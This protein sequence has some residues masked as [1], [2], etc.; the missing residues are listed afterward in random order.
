MP[1]TP[2]FRESS[3]TPRSLLPRL[4]LA[5]AMLEVTEVEEAQRQYLAQVQADADEKKK[6]RERENVSARETE[7]GKEGERER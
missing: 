5:D 7:K 4:P 3:A 2:S 1:D 6:E